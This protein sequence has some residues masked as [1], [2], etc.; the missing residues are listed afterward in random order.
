MCVVKEAPYEMGGVPR[1]QLDS[2]PFCG[3]S[4]RLSHREYRFHGFN[5]CGDKKISI[6]AQVICN[7][8]NARGPVA[9]DTIINPYTDGRRYLDSLLERAER[10]WNQRVPATPTSEEV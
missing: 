9:V 10:Y 4:A 8:C 2:C 3:K 6:A 5:G 7:G 1:V